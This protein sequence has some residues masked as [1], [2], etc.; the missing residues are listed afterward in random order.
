V[1]APF[2]YDRTYDPPAPFV[3]L[4]IAPPGGASGAV[5]A[6]LVDSGADCTLI[7]ASLA[8]TLRLPSVG[9]VEILGV[10][11]GGGSAPIHAGQVEIAGTRFVA[12]L[13]AYEDHVIVGRDL[14]NRLVTTLDGRRL[15]VDLSET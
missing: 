6:G 5:V 8:Q 9:L 1:S 11:G 14:L 12:R 10:G 4:R 13:V 15:Q 2:S 3:P 7:P